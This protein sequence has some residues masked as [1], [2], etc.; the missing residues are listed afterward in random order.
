[1]FGELSISRFVRRLYLPIYWVPE[2]VIRTAGIGPE[3]EL[4]VDAGKLLVLTLGINRTLEK[5][6]LAIS[7]WGSRDGQDW[8]TTPLL[9]FPQKYY[10]GIYSLLL[11]LAKDPN[12]RYVRAEWKINRWGNGSSDPMFAVFLYAEE[13]GARIGTAV[14]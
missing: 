2:C 8:G 6:G 3:V 9:S 14:A 5:Q 12:V 10:C 13:S 1:M 4:G 11:N 7:I